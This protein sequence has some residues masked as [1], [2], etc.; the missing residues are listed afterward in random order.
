MKRM[1][2]IRSGAVINVAAWDGAA[3]WDPIGHGLC[4]TLVDVT[5]QPTV[6]I[7]DTYANGVFTPTPPPVVPDPAGFGLAILYDPTIAVATKNAVLP[8]IKLLQDQLAV[9]ATGPIAAGWNDLVTGLP[10]SVADHQAIVG[11][12]TAHHIPGI[13]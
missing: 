5:G 13:S 4:D 9:G 2:M 3:A 8:W 10:I 1:A 7:G 11:Y 12:A 6:A